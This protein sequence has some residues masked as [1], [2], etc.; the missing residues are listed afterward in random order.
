[1]NTEAP[2]VAL[3]GWG[4]TSEIFSDF[5]SSLPE[6]KPNE[7][8]LLAWS[9]GGLSAIEQSIES[10]SKISKLILISTTPRFITTDNWQGVTKE[11]VATLEKDLKDNQS[12]ALNQFV[13]WVQFPSHAKNIW[14][15]LQQH[16]RKDTLLASELAYFSNLDLRTSYLQLKIPVLHLLGEQDPLLN[17]DSIQT[18]AASNSSISLKIIAGAG[19]APFLTH[20]EECKDALV[21]FLSST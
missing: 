6:I 1:M 15:T 16:L 20:P 17:I 7:S 13:Q 4:F 8:I 2:F 12:D 5:I 3:P 10:S 19:H 21:E 14:L 18:L 9:F 11:R